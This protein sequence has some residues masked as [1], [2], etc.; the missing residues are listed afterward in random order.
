M[1]LELKILGRKM[2]KSTIISC[3][4]ILCFC[5]LTPPAH[6]SDPLKMYREADFAMKIKNWDRAIA[7]LTKIIKAKPDMHMAYH[8]R[9]VAYSK[10]GMY[11][12]A[13]NDLKKAVE[14]NPKSPDSYALMGL[15]FDI[16]K[17]YKSAV[18]AFQK[19]MKLE[20]RKKVQKT[21]AAWI[22][23]AKKSAQAN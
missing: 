1:D 11:D 2:G 22:K 23:D 3:I 10:Q 19:A 12:Q 7:L 14:L 21:I 8:N 6:G 16:K 18:V 13:L 5:F 9:A 4:I 17:Q 15:L 20:K